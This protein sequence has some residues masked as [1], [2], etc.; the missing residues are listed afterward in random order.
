MAYFCIFACLHQYLQNNGPS[1]KMFVLLYC[2]LE[3]NKSKRFSDQSKEIFKNIYWLNKSTLLCAPNCGISGR[4]ERLCP[5]NTQQNFG[6]RLKRVQCFGPILAYKHGRG[7]VGRLVIG[8]IS[9]E[10]KPRWELC[11]YQQVLGRLSFFYAPFFLFS[12]AFSLPQIYFW[13]DL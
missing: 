4:E 8:S 13:K 6:K 1:I 10:Y 12:L 7:S 11:S 5:K 9:T 3:L 2:R